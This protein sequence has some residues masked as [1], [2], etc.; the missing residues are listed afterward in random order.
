MADYAR[1]EKRAKRKSDKKILEEACERYEYIQSADSHNKK[2]SESDFEFTYKNGADWPQDAKERREAA[3]EP[4]LSFPMLRQFVNQ[5][6]NDQ[7]QNRPGVRAHPAGDDTTKDDADLVQG[8]VRGIE[9]ESSAEAAYDTGFHHAVVGGRGYWRIVSEYERADSFNQV[10]RIKRI[11]DPGTVD[12][13]PDFMEPDGSD[14]NYG[15]VSEVVPK[16]DFEARWPKAD[17]VSWTPAENAGKWYTDDRKSV[18]VA[19][20]YRRVCTHDDLW[21]LTDGSIVFKSDYPAGAQ[22]PMGQDGLPLS[23]AQDHEGE[24]ISRP[25]KRYSVEWYKIAGGEQIL[26][27]YDWPGT[28]IPVICCMGDEIV[29][30]GKR[31]YQGL[32]RPAHDAQRMYNYRRSAEAGRL[33]LA[34]KAPYLAAWESVE[35]LEQFW[36]NANKVSYGFLPYRAFDKEGKPLPS[37]S[38]TPPATVET[39]WAESAQQDKQDMRATMGMYENS[40]GLHG[41]ETSGRAILAREKQGDNATFH[42]VDNLSRAIALTGKIIVEVLPYFY[43]TARSVMH[44][45]LDGARSVKQINQALPAGEMTPDAKPEN[46]IR[47]GKFAITVEAGPSYATKREESAD[48]L[49]QLVQAYPPLMQV[50]GDLVVKAQDMP[51]SDEIAERLRATLPPQIQQMLQAKEQGQDPQVQQL[52]QQLQQVQQQAQ[53]AL[54]GMQQQLQGAMQQVE[55]YKQAAQSKSEDNQIKVLLAKMDAQQGRMDAVVSLVET[56]AKLQQ[57]QTQPIGPEGVQLADSARLIA[58]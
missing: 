56:F 1:A 14:R 21:M 7:R 49:G 33:T 53:Q 19:D 6:A 35:G 38:R 57:A 34:T 27:T 54:Q 25:T 12:L 9:Y 11:V 4:C 48:K 23:I 22:L 45:G 47:T 24:D 2:A 50:A 20:Y 36:K 8:L 44:V 55:Q 28:I 51:D 37:P 58:Q 41:Q 46:D 5:V 43:D 3:G 13:D 52:S 31:V 42:F 30:N 16:V 26:E 17:A 15:F 32:V 18:V 10:L 29:L 40:L 39:G